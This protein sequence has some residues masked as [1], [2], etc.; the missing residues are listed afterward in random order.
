MGRDE[1]GCRNRKDGKTR[2]RRHQETVKFHSLLKF[3]G[4]AKIQSPVKFHKG[5]KNSQPLRKL[6]VQPAEICFP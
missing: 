5:C 3:A 2:R 4:A 1:L 6:G